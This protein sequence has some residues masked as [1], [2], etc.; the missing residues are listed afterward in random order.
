MRR[1]GAQRPLLHA[2]AFSDLGITGQSE[3]D[4]F[5]WMLATE[6]GAKLV[7]RIERQVDRFRL[8]D[9]QADILKALY[10]S[11][12]DPEARHDLGGYYTP[13]WLAA[14]VAATA[15]DSPL[16]QRVMDPAC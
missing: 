1:L 7:M 3:P 5:D 2:A 6:D 13:D 12:I 15:V 8:H 14:R 9:I 10:E 16:E 4:F 11:L